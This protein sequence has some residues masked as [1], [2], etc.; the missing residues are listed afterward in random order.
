MLKVVRNRTHVEKFI[1]VDGQRKSIGPL[2]TKA[3]LPDEADKFVKENFPHVVFETAVNNQIHDEG[4]G[5]ERAWIYNATGN[6]DSP[7]ELE[8]WEFI[9][10][11]RTKIRKVN[12]NKQPRVIKREMAGPETMKKVKGG[13]EIGFKSLP[14]TLEVWPYTRKSFPRDLASWMMRRDAISTVPGALKWAREPQEFEAN[15][16]WSLNDLQLYASLV[17]SKIRLGDSEEE[18]RRKKEKGDKSLM[19]KS[20]DKA[21]DEAKLAL[22]SQLWFRIVDKLYTLPKREDFEAVKAAKKAG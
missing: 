17:D 16:E 11:K 12:E 21:I 4:Y 8:V 19:G 18:I 9:N 2:E 13:D 7:D 5:G 1:V 20:L 22:W 15:P 6:P 10:R 14:R 3:V